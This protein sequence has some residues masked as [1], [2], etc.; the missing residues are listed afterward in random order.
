VT[1]TCSRLHT[2]ITPLAN[3]YLES[4]CFDMWLPEALRHWALRR[5]VDYSRITLQ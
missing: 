1:P 2:V 4:A 5:T 3:A